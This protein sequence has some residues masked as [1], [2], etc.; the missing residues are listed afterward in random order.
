MKEDE[1]G[2]VLLKVEHQALLPQVDSNWLRVNKCV[3]PCIKL[4]KNIGA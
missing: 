4:S 2:E 3:T 1:V